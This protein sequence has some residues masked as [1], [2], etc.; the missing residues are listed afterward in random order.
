M[1]DLL[2]L[3]VKSPGWRFAMRLARKPQGR[4]VNP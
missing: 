3:I 2:Q 1:Q 4:R